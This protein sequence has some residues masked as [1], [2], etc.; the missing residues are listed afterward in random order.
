MDQTKL[1]KYAEIQAMVKKEARDIAMQVY[2]EM[3]TQYGVAVVPTH[4][5]NNV[6]SNQ[7]FPSS[8]KDFNSLPATTGSVLS[9]GKLLSSFL[10]N[11]PQVVYNYPLPVITGTGADP[12]NGGD[13][14]DGTTL[15]FDIPGGTTRIWVRANNTWSGVNLPL[16]A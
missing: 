13:A 14:P 2:S 6:D 9:P 5:H 1:E 11:N 15:I 10:A 12:F 7:L 8:I 16:V 4:S 3:A